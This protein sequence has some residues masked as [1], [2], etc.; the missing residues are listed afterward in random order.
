VEIDRA[1]I[2]S[3]YGLDP[4]KPLFLYVG[5]LDK[6]K[7]ID[8]LVEAFARLD[9]PGVQLGIG[10]QGAQAGALKEQIRRLKL[11]QQVVL[12]GYIPHPDLPLLL[13]S[14]DIFCMPSPEE[15]QSI[16]SLEAMAVGRPILA[17]NAR[18][19]PELVADGVNG[20]LFTPDDAAQV[21][22]CMAALLDDRESWRRMS[23][24]SLQRAQAHSLAN[25]VRRYTELYQ[26]M[27]D[28][29]KAR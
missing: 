29:C 9:R 28:R 11:E 14:A 1:A 21:A 15:L 20:Y 23:Q 8:L 18:A 26:Q 3:K 22:N 7:R 24:S 6:E 19:L 4:D 25:T 5:R 16:A 27:V 10:G 2:R 17:A 12:T 13:N